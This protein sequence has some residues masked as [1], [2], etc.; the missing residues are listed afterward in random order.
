MAGGT[1]ERSCYSPHYVNTEGD[2]ERDYQVTLPQGRKAADGYK[3]RPG[4][5]RVDRKRERSFSGLRARFPFPAMNFEQPTHNDTPAVL[6]MGH[7]PS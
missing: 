6:P 5:G 2:Y 7:F 4:H 3:P 1:I